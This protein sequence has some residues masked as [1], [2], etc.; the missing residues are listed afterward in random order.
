MIFKHRQVPHKNNYRK[1]Q[2]HRNKKMNTRKRLQKI[3]VEHAYRFVFVGNK[4]LRHSAKIKF[5]Y[6]IDN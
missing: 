1:K 3:I 2:V 6:N 4:I 5:R